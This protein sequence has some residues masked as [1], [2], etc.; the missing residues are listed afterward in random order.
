MCNNLYLVDNVFE[1]TR[2]ELVDFLV[3]YIEENE[4]YEQTGTDSVTVHRR[5]EHH[6]M[7]TARWL[8]FEIILLK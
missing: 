2:K 4:L 6:P 1:Y 5:T 7:M 8:G 3:D